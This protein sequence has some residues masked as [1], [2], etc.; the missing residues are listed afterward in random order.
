ML[1]NDT[2]D[3]PD[4]LALRAAQAL[5]DAVEQGCLNLKSPF[6]A[7]MR[8]ARIEFVS[9]IDGMLHA[10]LV[11]DEG[12]NKA[13]KS[14][15]DAKRYFDLCHWV[16]DCMDEASMADQVVSDAPTE[17]YPTATENIDQ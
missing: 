8:R 13:R 6:G 4:E 17:D 11:T 15:A 2:I 14:Q 10:D 5:G 9:A 1:H 12:L 7:M 16:K 3:L